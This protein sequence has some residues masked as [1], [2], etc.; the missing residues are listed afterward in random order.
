MQTDGGKIK[1]TK[2]LQNKKKLEIYVDSNLLN[3]PE[4]QEA[5]ASRSQSLSEEN[6]Y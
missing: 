1:H 5:V 4:V 2:Q 6:P 3:S